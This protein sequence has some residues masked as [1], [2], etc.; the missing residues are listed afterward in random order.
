MENKNQSIVVLTLETS[1]LDN[2]G[3]AA[4]PEGSI[5]EFNNLRFKIVSAR[6]A[7][8]TEEPVELFK[9]YYNPPK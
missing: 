7:T 6:L 3:I 9:A 8:A 5:I 2:D 1:L 4:Y